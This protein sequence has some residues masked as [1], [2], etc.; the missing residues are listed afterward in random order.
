SDCFSE[1]VLFFGKVEIHTIIS[2]SF[3][4]LFFISALCSPASGGWRR[5]STVYGIILKDC[6]SCVLFR[7]LDGLLPK[8]YGELVAVHLVQLHPMFGWDHMGYCFFYIVHTSMMWSLFE[9][10]LAKSG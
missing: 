5:T 10:I 7:R 4:I 8:T 1:H 2:Y 6:R 9:M 3:D